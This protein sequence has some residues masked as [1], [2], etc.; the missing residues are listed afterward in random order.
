MSSGDLSAPCSAWHIWPIFSSSVIFARR[1]LAWA[2]KDL[3]RDCLDSPAWA[4]D[5]QNMAAI[6]TNWGRGMGGSSNWDCAD[7]LSVAS[8]RAR[9][10]ARQEERKREFVPGERFAAAL[11]ECRQCRTNDCKARRCAQIISC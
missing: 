5:R 2:S 8:F 11:A 6:K 4:I 1:A 3:K 7:E 10:P 9:Q